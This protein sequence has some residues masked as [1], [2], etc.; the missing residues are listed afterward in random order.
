[1]ETIYVYTEMIEEST[2]VT[3]WFYGSPHV[4]MKNESVRISYLAVRLDLGHTG[5]FCKEGVQGQSFG[6]S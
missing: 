5:E 4:F 2:L 6:Q 1:M 3:I